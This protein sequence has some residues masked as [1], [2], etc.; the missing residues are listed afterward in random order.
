V[1]SVS[2][3]ATNLETGNYEANILI[4]H[5][6][7]D[8]PFIVNVDLEVTSA[9]PESP[10]NVNIEI[11]DNAQNVRITWTNEGYTYNIYSSDEPYTEFP[12]SAW[13]LETTVSNTGEVII[14]IPSGERKF[15]IVTAE[16]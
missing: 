15:Y 5:N 6:A 3:D 9:Q 14:P 7:E 12:D 10:E 2:F 16:N 1:I 13:I 11:I 8:S 4:S